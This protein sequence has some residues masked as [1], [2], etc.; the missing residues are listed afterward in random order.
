MLGKC[1]LEL[2]DKIF[3]ID[4][5]PIELGSFDVIVGMD[6]LSKNQARIE[7]ADKQI[8]IPLDGERTLIVQGEKRGTKLNIISSIK[9]FKHLQNG[10]E[11]ILAYTMAKKEEKDIKDIPVVR[12]YPD[13]F[14]EELPGL[15][16]VRQV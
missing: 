13:V 5:M 4:L 16:P 9:A 15:P 12:D 1:K 10:C 2:A 8:H 11:A 6:W 7:C 14:P 3:E